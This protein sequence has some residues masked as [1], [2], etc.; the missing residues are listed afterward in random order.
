MRTDFLI[1][2]DGAQVAEG[3]LYVMGGAWNRLSLTEFPGS[4]PIAV[5]LGLLVGWEETNQHH[6]TTLSLEDEDGHV[7]LGPIEMSFEVGRPAGTT[8]GEEQRVVMA[9]NGQMTVPAPGGYAMVVR[10]ADTELG[11]ARFRAVP[12]GQP[13]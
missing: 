6:V 8:P 5:A 13:S 9:V 12:A 11:R 1:V 4:A 2:A 7:V 10:M 3:K